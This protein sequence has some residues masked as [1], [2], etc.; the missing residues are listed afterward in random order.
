MK[1]WLWG[2][3]V[4]L[5]VSL[6]A[7]FSS[8]NVSA[9]ASSVTA[10]TTAASLVLTSFASTGARMTH[11]V[12]HD[13]SEVNGHALSASRLRSIS[14]S[15]ARSMHLQQ[16]HA[17]A[18]ATADERWTVVTGDWPHASVQVILTSLRGRGG[19]TATVL[20]IRA[21]AAADAGLS[22][23]TSQVKTVQQVVLAHGWVTQLS[24]YVQGTLPHTLSQAQAGQVASAALDA[25]QARS[26][27]G[28]RT[29][30]ETSVSAYSPLAVN[31]IRTGTQRMNLQVAL[32]D[33]G[34]AGHEDVLV[35]S[36][37]IVD[38]Y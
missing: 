37:I 33:N 36:P 34:Y 8:G 19:A 30:H 29:T 28:L 2:A 16:V 23:F 26:V 4:V 25:V 3:A 7:R 24:A 18:R 6:A 1:R 38:A 17:R 13:Y 35:G 32:H 22:S 9:A 14:L 27:E 12:I 5:C 20:I 15:L 11:Y 31:F 21:D 10:A